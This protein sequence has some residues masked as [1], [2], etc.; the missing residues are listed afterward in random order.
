MRDIFE[1]VLC[2]FDKRKYKLNALGIGT[3]YGLTNKYG[4]DI[5][6]GEG[7]KFVRETNKGDVV[8]LEESPLYTDQL[9][10]VCIGS[11]DDKSKVKFKRH[12]KPYINFK[13]TEENIIRIYFLQIIYL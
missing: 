7:L 11:D 6:E 9:Y 13:T 8:I 12:F 10:F 4:I 2:D 3:K 5:H 1:Q